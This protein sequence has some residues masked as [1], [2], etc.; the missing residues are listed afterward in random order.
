[1]IGDQADVTVTLAN[2]ETNWSNTFKLH[3]TGQDGLFDVWSLDGGDLTS[4]TVTSPFPEVFKPT[5]NGIELPLEAGASSVTFLALPAVYQVELSGDASF[6]GDEPLA[7]VEAREVAVES[8]VRSGVDVDPSLEPTEAGQEQAKA[9]VKSWIKKCLRS[10]SNK[11]KLSE[12]CGGYYLK[13]TAG[14]S[15]TNKRWS[16]KKMPEYELGAWNGT[17][18]PV[19]TTKAGH[20]R[21]D[22]D[23]TSATQYGTSWASFR[24]FEVRG[25]LTLGAD[26][27]FVYTS[28]WE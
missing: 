16:L 6:G 1:M 28:E 21:W 10:G 12:A 20:I 25:V 5:V 19:T 17:G 18:W 4:V 13:A 23:V 15:Y 24:D 8:P 27:K 26:G 2:A 7:T 22:A 9:A 11:L 3:R 14:H